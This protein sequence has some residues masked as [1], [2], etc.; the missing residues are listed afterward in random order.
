MDSTYC[1]YC[2]FYG[3]GTSPCRLCGGWIEEDKSGS[4]SE[5][6]G[7]ATAPI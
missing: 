7:E 6:D 4:V 1:D 3:V 2:V 5:S